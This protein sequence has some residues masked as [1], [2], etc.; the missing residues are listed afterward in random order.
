VADVDDNCPTV[1]NQDQTDSDGDN[2]GDAC[3]TP[4]PPVDV[5]IDCKLTP[6][7]PFCPK[8]PTAPTTPTL[9][10]PTTLTPTPI[11]VTSINNNQATVSQGR[12]TVQN[13]EGAIT[14]HVFLQMEL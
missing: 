5:R 6:N 10:P 14:S 3:D 2:I 13:F 12:F 1:L 9:T 7:N 4:G 8:T 11:I